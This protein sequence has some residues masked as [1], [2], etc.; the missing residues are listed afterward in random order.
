[1]NFATGVP[2]DLDLDNVLDNYLTQLHGDVP[3]S[4]A[5]GMQAPGAGMQM[6]GDGL[7]GLSTANFGGMAG[8][9]GMQGMLNQGMYG[10]MAGMPNMAGMQM[11]LAGLQQPG[12]TAAAAGG[13]R[14]TSAKAKSAGT[15][16]RRQSEKALSKAADDDSDAQ[17][18]DGS[19]S[20]GEQKSRKKRELGNDDDMTA[21]EKRHLA[22][23]E[24]NRRAQRRFRERQKAK[25]QDL[26]QQIEE[27]TQKVGGLQ[28]ENAALHSRTSI[29]EK[30]L[31]M[32]NEQIQVMQESKE[33]TQQ[34]DEQT[35]GPPLTLTAVSGQSISLTT[36]MLKALSPEQIY[37]IYQ[38]YI[39]ELSS[40]LVELN[41]EGCASDDITAQ[42]EKLTK[43][44]SF[45]LMRLSVVRP[46]ETRKFI[47][48]SRQYLHNEE[49]AIDMWKSVVNSINLSEKQKLDI[50]QWKQL[51]MQKVEPIVDERKKLNV[52]IQA[53]LPQESFHTRNAITYIKTHEAVAK[54]RENLRAEHNVTIE[55]CAAVFKGVL[56]SFQMASLLVQAYP[57]VPDALAV[58]SAVIA[59]MNDKGQTLPSALADMQSNQG[60]PGL[61]MAA[62][63]LCPASDHNPNAP[64]TAAAAAAAAAAAGVL[65]GASIGLGAVQ[66]GTVPLLQTLQQS[67]TMSAA[68]AGANMPA[69]AV[70]S[71]LAGQ[72]Q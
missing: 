67:N 58:A 35:E 48:V 37:K 22:L 38:T 63:L 1:M 52:Q 56:N 14:Q 43:E 36:D 55:F 66:N 49:E 23:Q 11:G 28:T 8:L 39:K 42:V 54:L 64:S 70:D 17:S 68:P 25:I 24:K 12:M 16:G 47:A 30:V 59:D 51:F 41:Q 27:L 61:S 72:L 15:R 3:A 32:R 9:V 53:H 40:R 29:L 26:H 44:V 57:A 13:G 45:L 7:A 34:V 60:M 4:A 6:M 21:A 10:G 50:V 5:A 31:D 18:S 71:L 62:P 65:Q 19:A 69:A 33:I 2:E 46:I 20:S